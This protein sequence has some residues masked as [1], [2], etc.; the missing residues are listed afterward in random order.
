MGIF[1]F[2]CFDFD[3]DGK[4]SLFEKV[5]AYEIL[6]GKNGKKKK[7]AEKGLLDWDEDDEDENEDLD[8]L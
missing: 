6:T 5:V 1:D 2:K 3:G 7:P 4:V 8:S